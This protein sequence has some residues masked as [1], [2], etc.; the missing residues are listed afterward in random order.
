MA[1]KQSKRS[2]A[3]PTS[4][5]QISS[6]SSAKHKQR[7]NHASLL[8][9]CQ[10]FSIG[11]NATK[12]KRAILEGV[13]EYKAQIAKK[14][15]PKVIGERIQQQKN[16]RRKIPVLAPRPQRTGRKGKDA[17]RFLVSTLAGAFARFTELPIT[18]N[19]ED[20]TKGPSSFEQFLYPILTDIGIKDRRQKLRDHLRRRKSPNLAK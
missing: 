18:Q 1:T 19:W 4:G 8:K 17:E 7:I 9:H 2:T 15:V 5:Q 16:Q 11:K 20:D 3:I 6:K 14:Q 10:Q 12:L 13:D